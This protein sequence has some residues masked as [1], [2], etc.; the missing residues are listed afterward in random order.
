MTHDHALTA[1]VKRSPDAVDLF[2]FSAVAWLTHRIHFDRDYARSEGF[3]ELVVH[4]PLQGAYISEILSAAARRHG[5]RLERLAYRH[6]ESAFC[7]DTLVIDTR[8]SSVVDRD[9]GLDIGSTVSVTVDGDRVVTEGHST[10][11]LPSQESL[12]RMIA[13]AARGE[14]P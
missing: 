9:G 13:T 1:S 11:W 8:I 7:G 12:D 5:G 10:I 3:R 4:G 2:M 6:K 14:L